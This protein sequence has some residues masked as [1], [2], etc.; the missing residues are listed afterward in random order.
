M[1]RALRI[2]FEGAYYHVMNRG[3]GKERIFRD[4]KDFETFL[5]IIR[6]ACRSCRVEI[7]AYCLMNNHYHLLVHTPNANLSQFMRQINGVYTQK[8]NRRYHIDGTL[9]RGR[10]KAIVVQEEFYLIRVIRYIHQNPQKAGIVKK[11]EE[12]PW[13][14][15]PYFLK[16]EERDWLKFLGIISK[17]WAQGS[18]GQ[19]AYR[20]F[21]EQREDKDLEDFYK[22]KKRA[23]IFGEDQYADEI[24]QKYIFSQRYDREVPERRR[25]EIQR[26]AGRVEEIICQEFKLTTEGLKRSIRGKTNIP[27]SIAIK[28]IRDVSGMGLKE[29]AQRYGIGNARSISAFCA[30]VR[31]RCEEDKRLHG[32]YQRLEERCLQ[33][34]T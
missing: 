4:K 6:E 13:V 9:F 12:Y 34:E 29:I 11:A 33:V 16:G 15:H 7:T 20:E 14:S 21:M 3:R 28:L 18:Q 31:Q 23:F 26:Q 19:R 32:I 10:Y 2:N 24:S 25:R 22:A 1:A 30:R 8:Y 27:R 17:V 5:G